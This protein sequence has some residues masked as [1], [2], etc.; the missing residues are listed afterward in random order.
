MT[1]PRCGLGGVLV[2]VVLTYFGVSQGLRTSQ[3][4]SLRLSAS[5]AV[6]MMISKMVRLLQILLPDGGILAECVSA[7]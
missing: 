1:L 6:S 4:D 2:I 7:G 5:Q 3:D